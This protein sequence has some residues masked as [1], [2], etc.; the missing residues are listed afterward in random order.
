MSS[1]ELQAILE[2]MY[3]IEPDLG[4]K[5][6]ANV[7]SEIY[8]TSKED[9]NFKKLY[10]PSPS[11]LTILHIPEGTTKIDNSAFEGCDGLTDVHFPDSLAKIGDE[12]FKGCTRLT[13]LHFPPSLATIGH[14]AFD[15]CILLSEVYFS[16]DLPSDERGNRIYHD[17]IGGGAFNGWSSSEITRLQ[18]TSP[19]G[20][21]EID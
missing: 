15:G 21:F 20:I 16:S 13:T 6:K 4:D 17:E 7:V 2:L 8:A 11:R 14:G 19:F 5:I 9:E 1:V 10:N 18:K 12:A 3:S